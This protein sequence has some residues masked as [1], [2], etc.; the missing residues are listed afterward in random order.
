MSQFI[1]QNV[2]VNFADRVQNISFKNEIKRAKSITQ[3]S[4]YNQYCSSGQEKHC[5]SF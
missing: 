2:H 5:F 1:Q 3:N 4:S